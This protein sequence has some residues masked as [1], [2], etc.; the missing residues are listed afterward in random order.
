MKFSSAIWFMIDG[1]RKIIIVIKEEDTNPN[2]V[3]IPLEVMAT[4]DIDWCQSKTTV[5]AKRA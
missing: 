1:I 3:K 4:C 5:Q 2:K